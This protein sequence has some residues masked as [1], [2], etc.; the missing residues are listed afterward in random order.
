MET[1]STRCCTCGLIGSRRGEAGAFLSASVR[2]ELGSVIDVL[3]LGAGLAG[4]AAARDLAR[5]GADVT[6]L[7]ARDRVGGRVEQ[8]RVDE[9]R[10]VQLGGEVVGASTRVPRARRGARADA[11]AELRGVAGDDHVRPRRGRRAR[12]LAVPTAADEQPTSGSSGCTA[13]SS[14]RSTRTTLVA[15]GRSAARR[16][17]R[18]RLA[19]LGRTPARR[20]PR[21]EVAR[22][23]RRRVDRAHVAARRAPQVGGG[24]EQ[25]STRGDWESLQVAEGAPRSPSAWLPSSTSASGSARSSSSVT[26]RASGCRVRLAAGEEITRRGGRLR[27]PGRR[28]RAHRDRRRRPER[29]ASLR[30]QRTRSRPRSSP[31]T[32][33]RSGRTRRNGLAEGEHVLGSTWPQR[34]GVLSA[35]VPPERLALP[36]RTAESRPRRGSSTTSSS[37]CTAGGARHDGGPIRL[38]ATDPSPAAT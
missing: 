30:A 32:R 16:R 13:S 34:E 27:A 17:L 38:W 25:G 15:S 14:R 22:S 29:L 35:L 7:E 3:V 5:G 26:V 24:G 33:A 37:G 6:V 23:P 11:G 31:S 36:A 4:L 1:G 9:G 8:L 10:P 19:A 20:R 21:L 18:R 2:R 12:R 28:A